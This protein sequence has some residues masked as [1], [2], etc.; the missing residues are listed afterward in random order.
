MFATIPGTVRILNISLLSCECFLPGFLGSFLCAYLSLCPFWNG[1][2]S[3]RIKF[4]SPTSL[5]DVHGTPFL[6]KVPL[7]RTGFRASAHLSGGNSLT[8]NTNS[9]HTL[10]D[11]YCHLLFRW[12]TR[13]L[14]QSGS[15]AVT[16]RDPFFSRDL[17]GWL[18][19]LSW[20]GSPK[21]ELSLS[22]LA[23]SAFSNWAVSLTPGF[24]SS[25]VS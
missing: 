14:V 24:C 20:C 5:H 21:V 25:S 3:H 4:T 6:S 11:L 2:Q 22:G 7:E 15:M 8:Y 17:W 12:G 18:S 13:T 16:W 1:K 10:Q 23:V 19:V 9:N